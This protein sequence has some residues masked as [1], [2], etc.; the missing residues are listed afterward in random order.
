MKAIA[1]Q[2]GVSMK[3]AGLQF[4]LANPAV[5]AVIPGSSKP[6]RIG[7]D[8]EALHAVVPAKFWQELRAHNLVNVAAPLPIDKN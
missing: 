5:A 3:S 4:A 2:Y 7:E 8:I 1:Y 6:G